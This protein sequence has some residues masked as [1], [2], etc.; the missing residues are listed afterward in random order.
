MQNLAVSLIQ[1][2]HFDAMYV[3]KGFYISK[4]TIL[5]YYTSFIVPRGSP[6]QA[7][8]FSFCNFEFDN[9]YILMSFRVVFTM[10]LCGFGIVVSWTR[11]YMTLSDQSFPF[12][13]RK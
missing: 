3:N 7:M 10:I 13:T 8:L 5:S 11:F 6:L 12:R 2:T 4:E 9:D 1:K